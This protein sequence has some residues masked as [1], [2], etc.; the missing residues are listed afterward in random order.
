M[1]HLAG[2]ARSGRGAAQLGHGGGGVV[3]E[4]YQEIL[5]RMAR[6]MEDQP[7]PLPAVPGWT[8]PAPIAGRPAYAGTAVRAMAAAGGRVAA[9]QPR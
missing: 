1:Q 2:P 7:V 5:E 4:Y 8:W 9:G 3:E 6:C